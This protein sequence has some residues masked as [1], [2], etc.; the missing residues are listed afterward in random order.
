MSQEMS[1]S[2]ARDRVGFPTDEVLLRVA[3]LAEETFSGQPFTMLYLEW[4]AQQGGHRLL[5]LY[6]DRR[7]GH[8]ESGVT[9]DDCAAASQTLEMALEATD[10]I[11]FPYTLEVSSPGLNRPLV[12]RA[13]FKQSQGKT[14]HLESRQPIDGRKRFH[15]VL[16]ELSDDQVE[17]SV[18]GKTFRI[19][20]E[21]IKK[22]SL[23]YFAS[24]QKSHR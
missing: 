13:D 9:V 2:P 22:A 5:R 6:I 19:P 17:V 23:D 15:G 1:Q 16:S 12:S 21:A 4:G 7:A 18:D 11:P 24:D 3:E 8:G 20:L 14:I 10:P